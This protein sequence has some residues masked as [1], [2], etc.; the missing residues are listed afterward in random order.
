MT[1]EEAAEHQG[2]RVIWQGRDWAGEPLTEEGFIY[3]VS[4]NFVFVRRPGDLNGAGASGPG[5]LT[6]IASDGRLF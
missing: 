2:E 4:P 3:H 5:Q 1:I 6:L